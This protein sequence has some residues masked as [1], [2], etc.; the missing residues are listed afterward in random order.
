MLPAGKAQDVD[1]MTFLDHQ[2]EKR[3]GDFDIRGKA[4]R[5]YES[6]DLASAL[7]Y[8]E[9]L[10]NF[11]R[12]DAN[13]NGKSDEYL[14][15]TSE[16]VSTLFNMPLKLIAQPDGVQILQTNLEEMGP[17]IARG[18]RL[19]ILIALSDH[20]ML[21]QHP[22][23]VTKFASAALPYLKLGEQDQPNSWDVKLVCSLAYSLMIQG[24]LAA[25]QEKVVL[26]LRSAK[27]LGDPQLLAL[28]HQVNVW[29]LRAA[30]KQSE[31]QESE[32]F[33]LQ[34]SP[35]DP[36]HYVELAQLQAQQGNSSEAAQSWQKALQLFEGEK[37]LKGMASAHLSL[38]SAI[39][40]SK[41]SN[42]DVREN[43]EKALALY[44]QL[45]DGEGRVR[46][47]MFLGEFYGNNKEPKKASDYF[48]K[49][50]KLSREIK[51]AD[52]EAVVLSEAGQA[53]KHSGAPDSA[54][55][56]YKKSAAIYD[57]I[58]DLSDEA[59]QLNNE[60]WAL[61]DLHKQE[62]ACEV[63][64]K[65]KRR[66]DE[67][68]SWVARYWIRRTLAAGYENR[69]EFES[70]L[71]T[72]REARGISDSAHQALNSAWASL[73]LAGLL[74][75][76]GGWEEA[77]EAINI[78]LPILSQFKDTDNEISAYSSLMNIYGARESELKDL[79]KALGY[80]EAAYR[81]VKGNDPGRA[82]ALALEVE[83][84]YWQQKR[85]KEAITKA[86]EAL[87][88]YVQTNDDEDQGNALI[89]LAEAQRSDGDV[90]A[91]AIS[92][93]RAEPLVTHSQ[94]FYMTGRLYYGRANLLKTEGQFKSAIEQ[95]ERVIAMLEQIKSTSN[96]DI[97]RKASENYGYI[98][99][100]LIDTCYLL[101]N[102]DKQNKLAA[103][104]NALR[105]SELNKSRIFTNSWGRTFVDVLK[106][107]LPAEGA[108]AGTSLVRPTG[109]PSV[110]ACAV[111]VRARSQDG[112]R[113]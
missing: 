97:R 24:E 83:E 108:A 84:V 109:R 61:H 90:H 60:A 94:N 87:N 52:L 112:K 25:G 38:A 2:V 35:E 48:D 12:T 51:R 23:M 21:K 33:L 102:Q 49:A 111:D 78:S 46:S 72:L 17:I 75:D 27:R 77:L 63:A 110:R 57:N 26:C 98:Y 29:V 14:K 10:E 91:A 1:A 5:A 20:Y 104:D 42:D 11:E 45:G 66:A 13:W 54:L 28:A 39:T 70:A 79:D 85:F 101:G 34:H 30:G 106:L 22:E 36:Q 64:L 3:L 6:G 88:Y 58:K 37:N 16:T 4:T 81:M 76:V 69:G 53:Y 93:A 31:A 59:L 68:G 9:L 44:R 80:Y 92:L 7:V 65:A 113:D 86:T 99:D 32:R 56:Y 40:S 67:S 50:L 41:G 47:C 71:A 15:H 73:A 105:Y 95:Y 107:Q 82:A 43:L 96:L 55:E 62:E 89:S 74:T 18:A 100:E 19:P 103:A 8:Y